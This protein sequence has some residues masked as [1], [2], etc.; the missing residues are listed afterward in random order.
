MGLVYAIKN[1]VNGKYYVGMT[2]KKTF[3]ARYRKEWWKNHHNPILIRSI[4]KHGVDSFSVII[5]ESGITDRQVLALKEKEFAIRLNSYHPYG[6][7]LIECGEKPTFL[8]EEARRRKSESIKKK[9]ESDPEFKER[10]RNSCLGKKHS[11]FGRKGMTEETRRKI[12][13]SQ[14]GKKR[15]GSPRPD[16]IE[17]N[18]KR[19]WTGE[20]KEKISKSRKGSVWTPEQ[21][22]KL[23]ESRKKR[24]ISEDHKRKIAEANRKR[25]WTQESKNKASAVKLGN[26]Y[27]KRKNT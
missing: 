9:Y 10:H 24:R 7:N 1:L 14:K 23:L 5:L 18:K 22:V 13:Q 16:L 6:Y 3:S 4:E 20:M 15:Q 8:T 2:I 17:Y 27:A 11:F 25:K 12:S 21:R 19:V 26:Q